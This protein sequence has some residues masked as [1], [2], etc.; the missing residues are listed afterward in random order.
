MASAYFWPLCLLPAV[1]AAPG[2]YRT[3]SGERV[4]VAQV[5][6]RHDFGCKGTYG[7]GVVERW[8]KSG[9][10]LATSETANDVIASCN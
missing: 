10:I 3:R 1:I 6:A 5:S 4:T 8:H 9:R 2:Q 7:N